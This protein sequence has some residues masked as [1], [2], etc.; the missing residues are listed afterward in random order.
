MKKALLPILIIIGLLC[1]CSTGNLGKT[2]LTLAVVSP[3][4]VA[5]KAL[6]TTVTAFNKS[7]SEYKISLVI[8]DSPDQLNQEI[9][10]G[11]IPDIIEVETSLPFESFAAKGLFEDLI[12]YFEDDPEVWL[13]PAIHR[14]LST[15]DKLYRA[16]TDFMA[17]SMIGISDFVGAEPGWTSEEIT[18][19]LANAPEGATIFP[20]HW[21][22]A[23]TLLWLL[24]PNTDEFIDRESGKAL[25]DTP[26]F[27]NFLELVNDIPENS[28]EYQEDDSLVLE[29]KQLVTLANYSEVAGIA[30]ADNLFGGKL[31]TK[32]F[33]V[34]IKIPERFILAV[35]WP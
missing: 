6:A 19:Y 25:F 14:I 21:E 10:E 13:V 29:G 7:N 23:G 35:H 31:E 20:A 28:S 30:Y 11:N 9:I 32:G 1:G 33:Q 5:S 18:Q 22:K 3:A 27:K 4:G 26:D 24:Y 2:K 34:R 15:G 12:P 17:F 8:F 16:A